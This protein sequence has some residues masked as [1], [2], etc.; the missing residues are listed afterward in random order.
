[1]SKRP[2]AWEKSYPPGME[3][4]F[5][6][7]PS[8]LSRI[9]DTTVARY[10]EHR[11]LEYR[12]HVLSYADF[13]HR[14]NSAA[15]AL[16]REGIG[17]GTTL[18]L[19]MPNTPYFPATFFGG[20]KAGARMVLLSPLDAE[21]ELAYKLKDSGARVMVTT[22]LGSLLPMALKLLDAGHL[23]KL[24]VAE[25]SAWG[26]SPAPLA[27]IPDR[28]DVMTWADF[29]RGAPIPA[30][31]PEVSP[32]DI[33]LIQYTGGTTGLPK[34]AILTH[35]NLTA[36]AAIYN[37]WF[38]RQ[39]PST[40]GTDKI[41]CVLPLFH[42]Y[43]LT[44]IL[45]RQVSNGNEILLRPRFDPESVLQDIE[46]KKATIFP[47]VPT[48]WIALANL[49]DLDTRDFSSLVHC[50]S[51]GAPLPVEVG[52]RFE[53]LTGLPLLGGWGMTETAPAGTNLPC[54]NPAKPGSIGIPMPGIEMGI[55][56][57]EDPTRELAPGETG[58]LRV[59][60]PN[61]TSGYWHRPEETEQA[62]ADGYFLTGD[63]GTMDEDGYF[64]IVDRKKDMIL[65]G[66]FNV[67][68]QVV[69]QAIYEHPAVS[70]VL[71]VGI[72]DAYRGESA[73]AFVALRSGAAP[74]TLDELQAFLADKVG[75]HEM[76]RD[77]E[78]RSA[79]PRTAVGKFSKLQLKQEEIK[80]RAGG[81]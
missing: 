24:I 11:A 21:R 61:V 69:E 66:G 45:I 64:Y 68:P 14:V 56:A 49:A 7:E 48:M 3:W 38:Q 81:S 29:A 6:P 41:I 20:C 46:I 30:D 31:W 32:E 54:S 8:V 35:G 40:P 67:Y 60:G 80:K 15:A 42:I 18:A 37:N 25:D 62:F 39:R 12:G 52:K 72:P 17:A 47:G 4:D 71:V 50:S 10:P 27:E 65:S 53:A 16:L 75:R 58:E 22:D 34:G 43:A 74:F 1:M 36:S 26:A 19:Y 77:L 73:K 13:G 23:D 44:T 78:F 28:P 57:L 63:I 70:E 59:K 55:V 76:P 33:A 9:A 79:L 2:F 51:G 5:K